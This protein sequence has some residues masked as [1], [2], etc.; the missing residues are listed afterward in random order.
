MERVGVGLWLPFGGV[1]GLDEP[2]MLL[3]YAA[4][5]SLLGAQ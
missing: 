1:K 4:H 3:R 5:S 2:G